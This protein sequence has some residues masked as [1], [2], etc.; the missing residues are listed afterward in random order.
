MKNISCN[1][2][3]KKLQAIKRKRANFFQHILFTITKTKKNEKH[4]STL[5]RLLKRLLLHTHPQGTR[6]KRKKETLQE[7]RFPLP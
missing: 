2:K 4:T 6:K 3:Q 1:C 7:E 5:L